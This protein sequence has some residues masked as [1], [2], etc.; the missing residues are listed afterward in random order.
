M[1]G[2]TGISQ[3]RE[4]ILEMHFSGEPL[5]S[6]VTRTPRFLGL[7]VAAIVPATHLLAQTSSVVISQAYGG[8]GN[9]NAPLRADFVELFNRGEQPVSVTGWTLQYASSSGTTWVR[10]DLSG[11][12]QPGQYYLVQEAAGNVGASIPSPDA[13]GGIDLSSTS[14]KLAL[15]AATTL[16]SGSFP[17][18]AQVVDFVGYGSANAAAGSPAPSLDN[19]TAAFR[20]SNGCVDTK[21]NSSDFVTGGPAPR[22]SRTP[23][24]RC[25]PP[26]QLPVISAAGV[27]NAASFVSGPITP[28]E[29][30]TIF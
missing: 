21:N 18:G 8:G 12:L 14:G 29:I 23:F 19:N 17:A 24:N 22:N 30:V 10:T 13:V 11:T 20:R 3:Q 4:M 15:V 1:R 16:L 5:F 6:V 25:S 9:T 7:L 28:G 27:T 2:P 26:R